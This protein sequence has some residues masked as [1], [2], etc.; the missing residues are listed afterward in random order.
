MS[1]RSSVRA[2]ALPAA[3]ALALTASAA[4]AHAHV[5]MT[6]STTTAGSSAV[7]TFSVPHGC[8]GSP[9]VRIAIQIP[10]TITRVNPTRHPL[11]SVTVTKR[12]LDQP[13]TDGHGNQ[14]TQ[15]DDV[16]VYLAKTPL[17][18]GQRDAFE[19]ALTLPEQPGT[20]VFPTV[21]TCL[22]GQT[23]WNQVATRGQNT[24]DLD[25]PAPTLTVTAAPDAS[26]APEPGSD[27][28]GNLLVGLGAGAGV[29]GLILGATALVLVRR[30][31]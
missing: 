30:R 14:I 3:V 18:D 1:V 22:E 11:Y 15:R 23:A 8:D 27:S 17:P 24:H 19:L 5:G 12:T 10:E 9:T 13:I 2:L 29:L 20:L 25:R 16:I 6:A 4:P 31:G 7:L 26:P 28:G 21:Q